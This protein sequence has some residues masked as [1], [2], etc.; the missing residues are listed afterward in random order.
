MNHTA[1]P[2]TPP[3]AYCEGLKTLGLTLDERAETRLARYLAALLEA[4]RAF[5]LTAVT[6]PA[7]AWVRHILD[8]LTLCP[9]LAN[10]ERVVDLGSGGGLPGIPL[11]ITRP[12][13]SLVLVEATGKKARFLEGVAAELGLSSVRVV[14]DRAENA[15]RG[16]AHREQYDAVTGRAVGPLRVFLE[17][18]APMVRVGGRVLAV[19]GRDFE[20]EL[21]EAS[22]AMKALALNVTATHRAFDGSENETI[23]L[24]LEKR[25]ATDERYPRRPG[26]PKKKPL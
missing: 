8:S 9:W 24:V 10:G 25:A 17:L 19:K 6:D 21:T 4:N 2:L 1:S 22:G 16:P 7:T 13:L 3:P 15:G 5:N 26:Q 18:A 23:I 11:A 12:D 20:R 14:A